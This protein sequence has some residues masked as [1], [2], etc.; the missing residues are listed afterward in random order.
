MGS[1]ASALSYRIPRNK[2][3]ISKRSSCSACG[4]ALT[5]IDLIPLLSWAVNKGQCRQCGSKVSVFYPL[6]EICSALL[7]LGIY[8]A[9]GMTVQALIII[10]TIPFLIA[11]FLIDLEHKRL[12]DILVIIVASF[13]LIR[14]AYIGASNGLDISIYLIEY[15]AGAVVFSFIFWLMGML[16]GKILNKQALGLGDVKFA[17]ASG[18]WLGLSNLSYFL[19]LSGV[20]GVAIGLVWKYIVKEAKFPF[21]PALILSLYILLLTQGT[22]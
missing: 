1:F 12:P 19:I 21:G 6:Q 13:G 14:L 20:L 5:A 4:K 22:S 7:C 15:G 16:T 18:L 3:W 9:F 11:L 17:A 10:F 2:D 8:A